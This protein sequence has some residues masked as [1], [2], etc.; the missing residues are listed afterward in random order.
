MERAFG[1]IP[2]I[3]QMP[4][5]D[6]G[7]G[8][9]STRHKDNDSAGMSVVDLV[10]MEVIEWRD[11]QGL[12]TIAESISKESCGEVCWSKTL[13]INTGLLKSM[14]VVKLIFSVP[15]I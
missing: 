1:V 4:L 11:G 14:K 13:F 7:R 5:G 2:L 10:K 6:F 15:S 9:K 12:N 8:S 3:I